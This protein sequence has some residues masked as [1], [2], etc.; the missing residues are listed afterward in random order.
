MIIYPLGSSEADKLPENG[1][2]RRVQVKKFDVNEQ[3]IAVTQGEADAR[4]VTLLTV[5]FLGFRGLEWAGHIEVE[6]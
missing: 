6:S 1:I 4:L 5:R 3:A 2:A